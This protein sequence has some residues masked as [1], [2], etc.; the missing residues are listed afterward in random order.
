MGSISAGTILNQRYEVIECIGIGGMSEVYRTLDKES[1]VYVAL[2]ILKP[3]YSSNAEFIKRFHN[4][5]KAASLLEHPN[6]VSMYG[7]GND[8][9]IHYIVM[10]YVEGITLKDYIE[11]YQ[12]VPWHD[13]LKIT[14][15]I[16]L[17]MDHAHSKNVI[18]RDI[19]PQNIMIRNDN[20]VKLGDFGIAKAV[21]GAT[22]NDRNDAGSVHYL[23]PEQAKNSYSIDARSDIYSLGISLFEML[24]GV[25]PFDG[26]SNVSVALKHFN[27]RIM[28]PHEIDLDIPIGVSDLVVIATRKDPN[29]RFQ[30]AREMIS[31]I[32]KVI[33]NPNEPLID[34]E[35]D[36]PE[37]VVAAVLSDFS[38]TPLSDTTNSADTG[39]DLFTDAV[40]ENVDLFDDDDFNDEDADAVSE[41]ESKAVRAGR[42]IALVLTYTA[43]A[44]F[45][46]L[47]VTWV[48]S[49]YTKSKTSLTSMFE[50][51][52]YV[53]MD[54][55]GH[56][57]DG[58]V[59]TLEEKGIIVTS[60]IEYTDDLPAGVVMAQSVLPGVEIS[61]G[62]EVNILVSCPKDSFELSSDI[63]NTSKT[64]EE[65]QQI[66]NEKGALVESFK[67]LSSNVKKGYVVRTEPEIG[68]YIK[69]GQKVTLYV[70]ASKL[71]NQIEVPNFV[72]MDTSK[73][74]DTAVSAGMLTPNMHVG[75]G[76][77][78]TELIELIKDAQDA[79]A[80]PVPSGTPDQEFDEEPDVTVDQYPLETES[81]DLED[82]NGENDNIYEEQIQ[83]QFA[84]KTVVSQFPPAG[85]LIYE[86]ETV[87]LY[88]YNL[89][90]LSNLE[91][92]KTDSDG[93]VTAEI[94]ET[95]TIELKYPT[96]LV[97]SGNISY[98]RI[99][100][101]L[102]TGAVKSDLFTNLG[103]DD[104]PKVLSVPF[105]YGS[106]VTRVDIYM[107]DQDNRE[108]HYK[109]IYVYD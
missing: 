3:E 31:K 102:E 49:C 60:E 27:E 15:Q 50:Q 24:I 104:F 16:L 56:K 30:S 1:D 40:S 94:R 77:D 93:T 22:I 97:K 75:A 79:F 7:A 88:F 13:A 32:R 43:A 67:V 36:D 73:L 109:R 72:G 64:F 89:D 52:P 59:K 92:I 90:M 21:T 53:M 8:G 48:V 68:S 65:V 11:A 18:H 62:E 107:P 83:H 80:N 5:A 44:A 95:K 71:N 29:M 4:E 38:D 103:Y 85:T 106:D 37:A 33:D 25:V 57:Y 81:P 63:V 19:K 39:K 87:D 74:I 2:K 28:P 45:A 69:K 105:A 6:I 61:E 35:I 99:K 12:T 58:V 14:A 51:K 86:W 23:S 26:E 98:I 100:Y 46:V 96:D 17:A 10:E 41:N 55:E 108:I 101:T 54:F 42:I 91:N 66:L 20:S 84:S 76:S 9:D 47:A 78:I 70:C 34:R 82:P